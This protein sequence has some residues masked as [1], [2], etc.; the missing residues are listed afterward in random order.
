MTQCI[1]TGLSLI[2]LLEIAKRNAKREEWKEKVRQ[3]IYKG[4]LAQVAKE[5]TK[6]VDLSVSDFGSRDPASGQRVNQFFQATN[7][8]LWEIVRVCGRKDRK[9]DRIGALLSTN[10]DGLPQL[11]DRAMHGS[12]RLRT[13][14]RA[15]T[16]SHAGK[17]PLYQLHGYLLPP[18]GKSQ[19]RGEAADGLVLTEAEY[20][21]RTDGPYAWANVTLHWAVREFPVVF[22]G[23]SMTDDLIRRALLRSCRE[24]TEDYSAKKSGRLVKE[25]VRR[26]HFVVARLRKDDR[27]N[28]LWNESAAVLGLWPLWVEDYEHDL[29]A[30]IREA[31]ECG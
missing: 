18:N 4:F 20:V 9:T 23:C 28:K 8:L 3:A 5:S 17:I 1:S 10:L 19:I 12:R 26:R 25:T 24:R 14:E 27:I 29:P 11:C 21:A 16:E 15:S 13:V 6:I 31:F 22:V 2:S 7:P 30:K